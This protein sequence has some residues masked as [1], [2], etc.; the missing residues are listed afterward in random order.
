MPN[1]SYIYVPMDLQLRLQAEWQEYDATKKV[2]R[3]PWVYGE[4]KRM[5]GRAM[6]IRN[7]P[8]RDDT[9]QLKHFSPI[10][11]ACLA[12]QGLGVGSSVDVIRVI[13]PGTEKMVGHKAIADIDF[14]VQQLVDLIEKDAL[15]YAEVMA[16][17]IRLE[18]EAANTMP[19]EWT[20]NAETGVVAPE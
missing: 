16:G 2:W 18:D 19:R 5:Q 1:E 15:F 4:R 14:S 6:V 20:V 9:G 10:Q 17:K 7:I 8:F 3:R 13:T 11:A 12:L